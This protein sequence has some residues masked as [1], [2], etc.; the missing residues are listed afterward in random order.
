MVGTDGVTASVGGNEYIQ[1][2]K[3]IESLRKQFKAVTDVPQKLSLAKT[4]ILFQKENIWETNYQKQSRQWNSA[5]HVQKYYEALRSLQV[6]VDFIDEEGDFSKYKFLVIPAY[7]LVDDALVSKIS[8]FAEKGGHVVVTC[9]FGQKDKNARLWEDQYQAPLKKLAGVNVRFF[10]MLPEDK[11]GKVAYSG[12]NFEWNNW[13]EVLDLEKETASLATYIDQFYKNGTAISQKK[14]GKG[15]VTYI[16]VETDAFRLEKEVLKEVY[17]KG[18]GLAIEELPDGL[19]ITYRDGL[20]VA[21]NFHST[22][23]RKVNL[24]DKAKILI[25]ESELKPCGVLVWTE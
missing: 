10:D 9:R 23:T 25:G 12:K 21:L 20:W 14:T 18:T 22:E 19:D 2:I 5:F 16:G 13:A 1:T 4:A 7:Q 11:Y 8:K 17:K 6:P 3:E 24:S 15:S